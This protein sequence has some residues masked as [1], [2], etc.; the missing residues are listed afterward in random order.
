MKI[1]I[2]TFHRALNYGAVL[3]AWALQTAIS[4][5]GCDVQILDYR[6]EWMES[7]SGIFNTFGKEK[8]VKTVLSAIRNTPIRFKRVYKYRKFIKKYLFLSKRLFQK[9]L[10]NIENH[11]DTFITGSDQVWNDFLTNFDEAYFL[12]FVK[13]KEKK[14]SYAASFGFS[15]FPNKLK[16][17][18]KYRLRS[19]NKISVREDR[20]IYLVK[21]ACSKDATLCVDPTLLLEK[22]QWKSLLHSVHRKKYLLVYSLNPIVHL[23]DYADFL[24]EKQ[25]LQI[26]YICNEWKNIWDYRGNKR[27]RHIV[28][29]S[30]RDFISLI[31]NA[32]YVLTN[33]FHGTV[34][35]L[36]FHTKFYSETDYIIKKNDR[37]NSLLSNIGLK[38]RIIT[39]EL[40][41]TKDDI[42][43]TQVDIEIEHLK[44]QSLV[45][46]KEIC[47]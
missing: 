42:N 14:F 44:R 30:P 40:P 34:F 19:F 26:C 25:D 28:A 22:S 39:K 29:P 18:Y 38:S 46:L 35:S 1:A 45:Y 5:L 27:V 9:D 31:N 4:Q 2:I 41:D 6:N 20:G 13:D 16:N 7:Y 15:E 33:S 21:E 32:E 47:H 17:E 3:Q 43:W 11:F 37:I 24:A 8:T 23:M 36:I 10:H 12:S